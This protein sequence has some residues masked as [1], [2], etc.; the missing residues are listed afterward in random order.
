[1]SFENS[2]SLKKEKRKNEFGSVLLP[3]NVG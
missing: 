2:K 3:G 1:M